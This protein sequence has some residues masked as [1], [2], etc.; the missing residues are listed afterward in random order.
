MIKGVSKATAIKTRW[1]C[2][3]TKAEGG[4]PVLEDA[5]PGSGSGVVCL[6][7]DDQVWCGGVL[8]SS[9]ERLHRCDL[10][11]CKCRRCASGDDAVGNAGLGELA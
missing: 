2:G 10:N 5:V 8:E 3:D 1:C 9:D 7:D 4:G 11:W 6:I